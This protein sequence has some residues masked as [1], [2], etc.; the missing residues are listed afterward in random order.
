MADDGILV[1]F[2]VSD[3]PLKSNVSFRGGSWKDRLNAKRNLGRNQQKKV[4][5]NRTDVQASPDLEQEHDRNADAEPSLKRRKVGQQPPHVPKVSANKGDV[6]SSLFTFNPVAKE[7]AEPASSQPDAIVVPSNAPL[8]EGASNFTALGVHVTIASHLSTSLQLKAPT[9]IQKAA[10]SQLLENDCDAFIQAETGSGKTLAYLLPIIQRLML[11]KVKGLQGK[12]NRKSGLF[13]L[14]VAPTRELAKQIDETL[15]LLLKRLPWL[16]HGTVYGGT[17][18]NHEKARLRKGINIL[19]STPGRL[20]DHLEN[21]GNLDVGQVRWVVLDEGDRLVEL[22][23]EEDIKKLFTALDSRKSDLVSA[24]IE[25]VAVELP[26]RRTTILCSATMKAEVQRLG[27]IGLREAI[28]IEPDSSP[29]DDATTTSPIALGKQEASTKK[30]SVSMKPPEEQQFLAPSQLK[31]AYI[32]APAKQRLVT[33]SA[34]LKRTFMRKAAVSKVI[35]FLSCGDSVDFH[36]HL[37]ARDPM[38]EL[39]NGNTDATTMETRQEHSEASSGNG[40]P[41]K[42]DSNSIKPSGPNT[43]STTSPTISQAPTLYSPANTTIRVYKLHGNLHQHLRSSTLASFSRSTDPSILFCT[44][45]ASRG[46]DLPNIDLVIEYDPAASADDHLHRVGR[47]ARAGR[48][49]RAICFLMPGPEEGYI[50]TLKAGAGKRA[51]KGEKGED[52]LRKGFETLSRKDG[53]QLGKWNER[54]TEWQLELE[55]WIIADMQAGELARKAYVSHVRAYATHKAEERG[56]FNVKDLHLGHLAK[57]FALREKPG[58]M[59]RGEVKSDR[60]RKIVTSERAGTDGRQ[61]RKA[62]DRTAGEKSAR[63]EKSDWRQG[64]ETIAIGDAAQKMRAKM[65]E[66]MAIAGEFNIG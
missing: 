18:K 35:V 47:T 64:D 14:I 50:E 9:A 57:A 58:S 31:Q 63:G 49:G 61:G 56:M 29:L 37:F 54:A 55:R 53:E 28:T 17:T 12:I 60:R 33:L 41:T 22:G 52:V 34:L 21:T 15:T 24:S 36:F 1:N 10:L 62:D 3:G 38:E 51:V 44:D 23:F 48:D 46:L 16:V 25:H 6:I 11:L 13:A 65:K 20:I 30:S 59:G 5:T 40:R 27:S 2:Q 4:R 43:K 42:H 66:H 19:V 26:D 8:P 32:I 45:V 7:S 39:A